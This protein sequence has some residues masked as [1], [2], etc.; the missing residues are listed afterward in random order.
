MLRNIFW[1]FTVN[2]GLYPFDP[3]IRTFREGNK[4]EL[5]FLIR[6]FR[7]LW[8]TSR[9]CPLF[10]KIPVRQKLNGY[11]VS[12]CLLA[13]DWFKS[14]KP[15]YRK[16]NRDKKANF[17]SQTVSHFGRGQFILRKKFNSDL[18]CEGTLSPSSPTFRALE[19][20][21]LPHRLVTER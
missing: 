13:Y 11:I 9:G 14:V 20:E 1:Y 8:Y 17:F 2:I 5:K 3:K 21:R 15:N 6:K 16:V 10:P 12:N 18:A 4:M 19:K 7:K